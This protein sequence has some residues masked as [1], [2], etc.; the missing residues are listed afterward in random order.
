MDGK[1][2]ITYRDVDPTHPSN[3]VTASDLNS[4]PR[5]PCLAFG[6]GS[7]PVPEGIG[8]LLTLPPGAQERD[9]RRVRSGV[10]RGIH[11]F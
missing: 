5:Y 9:A 7:G 6:K 4:V 10:E 1:K 3:L 8:E 2:N 11:I